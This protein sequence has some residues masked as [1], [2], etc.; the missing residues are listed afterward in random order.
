MNKRYTTWN[1]YLRNNFGEKIFK[2]PIDAGF[3]CP[4]RDGTVAH[5]GCTFCTVSGSGDMIVAPDQPI[6]VQFQKE[7]EVFHRKWPGVKKI[8]CLFPKLYEYTCACG[9]VAGAV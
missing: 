7:I 2:V 4:N 3:D 6:G 9:G 8:H 5:G 1:E